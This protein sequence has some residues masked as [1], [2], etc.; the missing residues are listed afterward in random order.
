MLDC[1]QL[2]AFAAV[3][4]HQSFERA[5][6]TLNI[7]RGAI[8]QRIK[9]L[10]EMLSTVLLIRE[11]PVL[12]T[13][14]G[15]ILL[16]HVKALQLMEHDIYQRIVPDADP[17]ERAPIAIAVNADSLATWFGPLAHRIIAQIQVALEIL[18]DDQDH[19][20]PM[21]ARGEAIGCISTESKPSHG[22]EVVRLGTMEYRCVAT[23][24]FVST[25]FP[26]GLTVRQIVS[27][28]AI[29]FN[30]KD[31]L[32]D[33]FLEKRFGLKIERYTKH[34][35]PSPVALLDAIRSEKGYGMVPATQAE[36]MLNCGKLI[37]LAPSHPILVTLYWHHWKTEPAL[38]KTVTA[39]IVQEAAKALLQTPADSEKPAPPPSLV[40]TV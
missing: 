37:D 27:T 26:D 5:A 3:I 13:A 28:P 31:S 19:T 1:Y 8:S 35:F 24:N 17:R 25:Y 20:W 16:R 2:E 36:P 10:E 6:N 40:S 11:R 15:E 22:F 14:A 9:L 34:Y 33:V 12:P 30:R 39:L 38:A 7:S 32:H 4:K 29:L 23:P 18:V 21:L